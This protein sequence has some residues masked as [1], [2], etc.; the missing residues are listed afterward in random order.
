MWSSRKE[1]DG[2][3]VGAICKYHNSLYLGD[4]PVTFDEISDPEML[5]SLACREAL[6]L[7]DDLALR[8]IQLLLIA[9]LL[10]LI[11]GMEL[12]AQMQQALEKLVCKER[13]FHRVCSCMNLEPL[14]LKLKP[15]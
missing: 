1:W 11:F 15:G 5:E 3:A 10:F 8:H 9:R 13:C 14:T 4:S 12:G 7:A 2:N 6:A